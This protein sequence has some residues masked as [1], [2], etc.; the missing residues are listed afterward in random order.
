MIY[1]DSNVAVPVSGVDRKFVDRLGAL[2]RRLADETPARKAPS[3]GE[4]RWCDI[5]TEDCPERVEGE[6]P[7]R[8][9]TTDDF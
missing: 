8:E 7:G 9:G 1:P 4:C 6:G 5:T 2:I 3:G